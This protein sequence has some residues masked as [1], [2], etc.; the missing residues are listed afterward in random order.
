VR[1]EDLVRSALE[2]DAARS[3]LNRFLLAHG[4]A[5]VPSERP[6]GVEPGVRHFTF[7]NAYRLARA[8]P[9]L[10]YCE[11]FTLPRGFTDLPNRHAW[12]IDADDRVVDP[13]PLWADPGKPLRECYFGIAI[14]LGFAAPYAEHP[15]KPTRG[16]LFELTGRMHLLAAELGLEPV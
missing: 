6:D 8:R 10:S 11:G 9:D 16:V 14:P 12:C 15:D 7:R 4:K 3:D 2:A 5:Y 13:S 1:G